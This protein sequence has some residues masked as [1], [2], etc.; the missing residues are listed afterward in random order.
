MLGQGLERRVDGGDADPGPNFGPLLDQVLADR[1]PGGRLKVP[2]VA[3]T[4]S[5]MSVAAMAVSEPAA[6]FSP[7]PASRTG[8]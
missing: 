3:S 6:A 2:D 7:L 4:I 5:R 1:V 8:G